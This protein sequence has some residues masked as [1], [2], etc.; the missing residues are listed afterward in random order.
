[1]KE[2]V[3]IGTIPSA[4]S[5]TGATLSAFLKKD[6]S[7]ARGEL[8]TTVFYLPNSA[9]APATTRNKLLHNVREP[10]CS[11]NIVPALV[12]NFR[13]STNKFAEAGYTVIYDKDEVNF[14][15]ARTRKITVSEEAILTGW[16]CLH[17]KMWH[18]PLV[19]IVTNLNTDML[20]LDHPSRLD[21]LNAMYAVSSSTVAC[22]HMAL[23]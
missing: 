5:D 14:Y 18:I 13:L 23:H 9:I 17:Q 19:P 8:S 12:E 2:G 22:N 1:M 11:V 6:P 3:L 16:R 4:V 10:A 20:L 15:N 21:S 7:R